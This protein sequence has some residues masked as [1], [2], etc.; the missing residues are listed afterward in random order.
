[1][2]KELLKAPIYGVL[3][4]FTTFYIVLFVGML[5]MNGSLFIFYDQMFLILLTASVFLGQVRNTILYWS[6]FVILFLAYEA[7]R[8]IVDELSANVIYM[9]P[10]DFEQK[11]F[12][13]VLTISFQN[14]VNANFS[15]ASIN[16]INLIA[17]FLYSLHFIAPMVFAYILFLKHKKEF[18]DFSIAMI[19]LSYA[20]LF[21]FLLFPTAPPWMASENGYIDDLEHVTVNIANLPIA[22]LYVWINP[23][24]IAAI[25]SLHAAYPLLITLFCIK[26]YGKKAFI[27][28]TFPFLM[29]LA[30]IY[31]GEHYLLDALIGYLYVVGIHFIVPRFD[32][33]Y[34]SAMLIKIS[35]RLAR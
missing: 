26:L 17:A 23:N 27:L 7:M 19:I 33:F 8:G 2:N 22:T 13:N 18:L 12:G 24:P 21:T 9:L 25:P 32:L 29:L 15:L 31:L 1:M 10:I 16:I 34:N 20:A 4:L 35:N 6:P 3:F 28:F 14:F 11:L 30:L 5:L